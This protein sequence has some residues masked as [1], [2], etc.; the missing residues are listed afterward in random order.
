MTASPAKHSHDEILSCA[1][2]HDPA[3]DGMLSVQDANEGILLLSLGV[4]AVLFL[5]LATSI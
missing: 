4:I 2:G 1:I 5:L 3:V